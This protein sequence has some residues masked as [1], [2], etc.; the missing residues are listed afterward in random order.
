M[1]G[2]SAFKA[3]KRPI[4]TP[5]GHFRAAAFFFIF[6]CFGHFR[7]AAFLLFS[8]VLAIFRLQFYFFGGRLDLPSKGVL[9]AVCDTVPPS[10]QFCL[11]HG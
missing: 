10:E 3:L 7:S 5:G 6:G 9:S 8:P 11:P 4:G 1:G 2:V